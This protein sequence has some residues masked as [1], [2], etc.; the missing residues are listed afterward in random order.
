MTLLR[1]KWRAKCDKRVPCLIGFLNCRRCSARCASVPCKF[2]PLLYFFPFFLFI[3]LFFLHAK[4]STRHH[5]HTRSD[6]KKINKDSRTRAG[7]PCAALSALSFA[8][9][10]FPTSKK[11]KKQSGS[12]FGPLFPFFARLEAHICRC[13]LHNCHPPAPPSPHP[14]KENMQLLLPHS[15]TSQSPTAVS[16]APPTLHL[17]HGF[18]QF[19]QEGLSRATSVLR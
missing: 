16:P 4:H 1:W 14:P 18:N 3:Y 6:G 8:I 12:V 19:A 10:N 5:A 9:S 11:K 13:L 15:P 2:P 7:T 17:L